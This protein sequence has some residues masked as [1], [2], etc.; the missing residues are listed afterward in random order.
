MATAEVFFRQSVLF[1]SENQRQFVIGFGQI[2]AQIK[3][4]VYR[5]FAG[6]SRMIGRADH[7]IAIADGFIERDADLRLGQHIGGID[8]GNNFAPDGRMWRDHGQI[9][10]TFQTHFPFSADAYLVT[11][12]QRLFKLVHLRARSVEDLRWEDS[13]HREAGDRDRSKL[14]PAANLF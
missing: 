5:L 13:R 6:N 11:G 8:G 10:E 12:R 1:R 3:R 4:R 14:I 7:Q 2:S 9:A